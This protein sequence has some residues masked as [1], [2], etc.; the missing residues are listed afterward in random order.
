M[1]GGTSKDPQK[2][3]LKKHHAYEQEIGDIQ[4]F[5]LTFPMKY[6][7]HL[8]G[9]KSDRTTFFKPLGFKRQQSF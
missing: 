8:T 5:L 2:Y 3:T 7:S 9:E 6:W 4:N 1:Y